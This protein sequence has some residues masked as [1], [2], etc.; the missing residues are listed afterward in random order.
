MPLAVALGGTRKVYNPLLYLLYFA[1]AQYIGLLATG[2]IVSRYF[3]LYGILR[4]ALILAWAT[5][6][7][8]GVLQLIDA[9]PQTAM[10]VAGP[11]LI[12][13]GLEDYFGIARDALEADATLL[14]A[15]RLV[16]GIV[17]A[18]VF[19]N[20]IPG[21]R[22]INEPALTP[23]MMVRVVLGWLVV[24]YVTSILSPVVAG[25]LRD[26]LGYGNVVDDYNRHAFLLG[27]AYGA[28][29]GT[30]IGLVLVAALRACRYPARLAR[31][32]FP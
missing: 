26:M 30:G 8:L 19:S 27:I 25:V 10:A 28:V 12:S 20:A 4:P 3:R 6:T 14:W 31:H 24:A 32:T 18:L 13:P 21:K 2:L 5:V 15:F 22:L 23:P 11:F 1:L 16:P 29:Y 9:T 7:Y 17:A